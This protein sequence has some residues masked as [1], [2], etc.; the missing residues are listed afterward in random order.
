MIKSTLQ[1]SYRTQDHIHVYIPKDTSL[2]T[3]QH[4]QRD[5]TI[6]LNNATTPRKHLYDLRS[7]TSLS[8][9]AL[10]AAIKLKAHPNAN[11]V[12]SAVVATHDRVI[13]MADLVM[14]IQPGGHFRLFTNETTAIEWLNSQVPVQDEISRFFAAAYL[15]RQTNL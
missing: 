6:A 7:L 2:A 14:R 11:N 12:Y 4:W 15:Y 13:E 5:E 3:V 8:V 10:H 1:R 9:Y